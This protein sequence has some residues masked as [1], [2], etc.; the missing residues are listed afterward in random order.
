MHRACVQKEGSFVVVMQFEV[1][2]FGRRWMAIGILQNDAI[3]TQM[4]DSFHSWILEK[5]TNCSIYLVHNES[6]A[7]P[8]T[9]EFLK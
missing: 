1:V 3:T 5:N 6:L 7:I 2:L 8:S 4:D 9:F